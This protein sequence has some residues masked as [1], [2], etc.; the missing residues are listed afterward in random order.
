MS[1]SLPPMTAQESPIFTPSNNEQLHTIYAQGEANRE[2]DGT[3]GEKHNQILTHEGAR[4]L[5]LKGTRFLDSGY[6]SDLLEAIKA[7][8]A[9]RD[10]HPSHVWDGCLGIAKAHLALDN[11]QKLLKHLKKIELNADCPLD[12]KVGAL[13]LSVQLN[14]RLLAAAHSQK[15]NALRKK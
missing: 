4:S 9:C 5:F 12:I 10:G 8:K 13:R 6:K 2:G 3:D 1:A 7:F 15:A 11:R 14:A